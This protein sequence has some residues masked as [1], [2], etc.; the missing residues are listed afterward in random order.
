M[1]NIISPYVGKGKHRE[2][3]I[4]PLDENLCIKILLPS[5]SGGA[6]IEAEREAKYYRFLAKKKV[7]WTMLPAFHG[8]VITNRG[9]GYVFDLI[10]DFDGN[11]SK[12]LDYYLSKSQLTQQH[13]QGLS[14][15]FDRLKEYLLRWKII[16]MNIEDQNLVYQK[17]GNNDGRLVMVDNLGN[18]EFI[19][20]SNYLAFFA[21]LKI[22]RK[23][24]RFEYLLLKKYPYNEFLKKKFSVKN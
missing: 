4:H 16:T 6:F 23:W 8:D 1:L 15:A 7:P 9:K 18:S 11:V 13:A 2:C 21:K 17:I 20:I 10:R 3:Y 24:R 5:K 14:N 19:P 12:N 22:R